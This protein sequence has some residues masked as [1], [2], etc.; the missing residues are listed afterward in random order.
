MGWT[1][2][3]IDDSPEQVLE[4]VEASAREAVDP[5]TCSFLF[6]MGG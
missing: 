1:P 3:G 4:Y 5:S 2:A 6:Y